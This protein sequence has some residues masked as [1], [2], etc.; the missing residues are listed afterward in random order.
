VFPPRSCRLRAQAEVPSALKTDT[1]EQVLGY[2]RPPDG[3]IS[4][5]AGAPV[6]TEGQPIDTSQPADGRR[7]RE[8]V[9]CFTGILIASPGRFESFL[10]AT[11]RGGRAEGVAVGVKDGSCLDGPLTLYSV[12]VLEVRGYPTRSFSGTRNARPSGHRIHRTSLAPKPG[13]KGRSSA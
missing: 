8:R 4:V 3:L 2:S 5:L 12:G 11:R 13:C 7:T 9:N 1:P 10:E 6:R